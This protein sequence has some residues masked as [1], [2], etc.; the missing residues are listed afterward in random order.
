MFDLKQSNYLKI[1]AR[2]RLIPFTGAVYAV[3]IFQLWQSGLD[4]KFHRMYC[5]EL[6]LSR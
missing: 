6:R 5:E 2:P 4:I 1:P 3:S